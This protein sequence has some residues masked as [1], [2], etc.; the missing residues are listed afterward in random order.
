MSTIQ[1]PRKR[2]PGIS[3]IFTLAKARWR[4]HW[5]LLLVITLGMIVSITLVC[6]IPLLSQVLQTAGLRSALTS[7]PENAE[8]AAHVSVPGL[9]T[10]TAGVVLRALGTSIRGIA[11]LFLWEQG[12]IYTLA[13]L[14]GLL[15]GVLLVFTVVPALVFTGVPPGAFNTN[16][17]DF[18]TLQH[19]IPVQVA[20]PFSLLLA[21]L[22]FV[23][24]CAIALSLIFSP[25]PYHPTPMSRR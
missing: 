13:L 25:S 6:T 11:S 17:F 2:S 24:T 9:S 4:Q 20:L 15:F 5:L 10:Q 16:G 3:S 14:L 12:I 23:A 21:L 18:L 7:P 1:A 8:L 22:V 19:I